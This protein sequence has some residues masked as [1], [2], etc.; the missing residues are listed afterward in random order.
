MHT[1][2]I[3]LYTDGCVKIFPGAKESTENILRSPDVYS[4]LLNIFQ[5]LTIWLIS[6]QVA[7]N[8]LAA[9][10]VL[11]ALYSMTSLLVVYRYR[12]R[13]QTL[14]NDKLSDLEYR[15]TKNTK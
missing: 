4:G 14:S 12:T 6:I 13:E 10:F 1:H 3:N 5:K 8:S 11:S 2:F 15:R 9:S 7:A